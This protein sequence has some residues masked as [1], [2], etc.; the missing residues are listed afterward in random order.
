MRENIYGDP[1]DLFVSTVIYKILGRNRMSNKKEDCNL[2]P[3]Y[4]KLKTHE[5]IR[6]GCNQDVCFLTSI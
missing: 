6:L 5:S 1:L 4:V 3:R 2:K